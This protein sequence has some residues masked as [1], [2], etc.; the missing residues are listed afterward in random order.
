MTKVRDLDQLLDVA[1]RLFGEH[2]YEAT[3]LE[4][5]AQ[6]K[7]DPWHD[8]RPGLHAA[9]P[10]DAVFERVRAHDIFV[11]VLSRLVAF[12]ADC[13]GPWFGDEILC[14]PVGV[15]LTGSKLVKVVVGRYVF[16]GVGRFVRAVRPLHGLQVSQVRRRAAWQHQP[17]TAGR[18]CSACSQSGVTYELTAVHIVA[19]AGDL[20]GTDSII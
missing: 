20:P 9:V 3:T 17:R 18:E 14:I 4:Q 6:R 2:G 10:V 16:P 1:A 5:I 15:L 7:S 12:A 11:G 19:L 8:H 13:H